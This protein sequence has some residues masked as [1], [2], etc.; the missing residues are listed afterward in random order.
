MLGDEPVTHRP[1][2]TTISAGLFGLV[3]HTISEA[4]RIFGEHSAGRADSLETCPPL[5]DIGLLRSPEVD[6]FL[7]LYVSSSC[8]LLIR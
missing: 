1:T 3:S 2:Q 7:F 8:S 4:L 5:Y 6:P